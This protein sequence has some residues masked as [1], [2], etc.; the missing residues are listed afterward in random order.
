VAQLDAAEAP[1][2]AA[3]YAA[4]RRPQLARTW[5]TQEALRRQPDY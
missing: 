4:L 1:E 3:C 2:P 5:G